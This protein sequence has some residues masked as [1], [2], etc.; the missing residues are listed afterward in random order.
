MELASSD[1]PSVDEW[2][3]LPAPLEHATTRIGTLAKCRQRK[4][5]SPGLKPKA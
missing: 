5:E 4:V 3:A 1:P 2:L